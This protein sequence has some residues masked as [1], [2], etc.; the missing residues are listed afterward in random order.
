MKN[1]DTTTFTS[2]ERAVYGTNLINELT[3]KNLKKVLPQLETYI[4]KKICLSKGDKAK[5]FS[6]ELLE[7]SNSSGQ[8][9]RTYIS[10]E[11]YGSIEKVVLN[12]DVTVKVKNYEGGGYGVQYHKQTVNIGTMQNGILTSIE[13]IEQIIQSY[14]LGT[15]FCAKKVKEAKDK[16]EQLKSEVSKLES[17]I[18]QFKN[19]Y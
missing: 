16:I 9:L 5:S 3:F 8:H 19:T 7:F 18:Y 6:I 13:S 4:N 10:F 17:T 1:I 15:I 12:Q 11:F 14:Q 2:L